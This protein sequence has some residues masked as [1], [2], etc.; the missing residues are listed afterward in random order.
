MAPTAP[1]LKEK[2]G[3]HTVYGTGAETR[4]QNTEEGSTSDE[5]P[6]KDETEEQL[7]KLLF[8][9]DAGFLEGLKSHPTDSQITKRVERTSTGA[10]DEGVEEDLEAIADENVRTSHV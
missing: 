7:E 5:I 2:V 10:E 3:K 9:D 8:G 6:D 1:R 4:T